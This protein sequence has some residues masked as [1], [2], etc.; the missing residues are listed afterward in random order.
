MAAPDARNE[1]E[2][3]LELVRLEERDGALSPAL[4]SRKRGLEV[5]AARLLESR[6]IPDVNLVQA[7]RSEGVPAVLVP[8]AFGGFGGWLGSGGRGTHMAVQLLACIG[9][10]VAGAIGPAFDRPLQRHLLDLVEGPIS[11]ILLLWGVVYPA[12]LAKAERQATSNRAGLPRIEG[13]LLLNGALLAGAWLLLQQASLT[14]WTASLIMWFALALASIGSV[15]PVAMARL[16]ARVA[17][18]AELA[19]FEALDES[20]SGEARRSFEQAV[21]LAPLSALD[22]EIQHALRVSILCESE[23]LRRTGQ[24][25]RAR[26]LLIARGVDPSSAD[27]VESVERWAVRTGDRKAELFEAAGLHLRAARIYR[28]HHQATQA[29]RCYRL[30]SERPDDPDARRE[31]ALGVVELG[32]AIEGP[33]L[34][35]LLSEIE[36][37]GAQAT[38]AVRVLAILPAEALDSPELVEGL[39]ER[40]GR[41]PPERGVSS[42]EAI[43]GSRSP[44]ELPG[45]FSIL[46]GAYRRLGHRGTARRIES[47]LGPRLKVP[48]PQESRPSVA[49]AADL[50]TGDLAEA[51]SERYS[52]VCRLGAGAM[53][54]VHLAE[55]L[56]LGR[57]VALKVLR[58]QM[59]SDL[60]VE[61][62]K[63]EARVVARLDHPG[64]V[65]VFDAGQVG[66]WTY[67]VMELVDG[68]DLATVT[69]APTHPPIAT[70][71][72]WIVD[73]ASAMA[74]AHAQGVIHRDIKPANILIDSNGRARLTDFGIA[75]ISTPDPDATGFSKAGLQVGTPL[76]M[77]P[78]QL[79]LGS[80][81]G[82][83]TD[84]Y[85]LGVV[86]YYTA[87]G[88]LPFKGDI[89][90]KI[91]NPAPS[92]QEKVPSLS[93]ELD[94]VVR[95]AMAT[96]PE[97]RLPGMSE[98]MERL[99]QC[100]ELYPEVEE[101]SIGSAA[102]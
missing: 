68:P 46:A 96:E 81:P 78:E 5:S 90:S 13:P 26:A 101:R 47:E 91:E 98:L 27:A 44:S 82:P 39:A 71:L 15:R 94:A 89:V 28:E 12:I 10:V 35:G 31:A 8:G 34:D 100:P 65:R 50:N 38:E 77:A 17:R 55:D 74:H 29:L 97:E 59:A 3:L 84:V 20:A 1:V 63:T 32:G 86:L 36:E 99:R 70:L 58:P 66:P 80:P 95:A 22:S 14:T 43:V 87:V 76:Y 52:L 61:K 33:L 7:V 85:A 60:F 41:S 42:V 19:G 56:V 73:I 9:V 23:R 54:E 18:S 64:I 75:H 102:V 40:L 30:V 67:F 45:L 93:V 37:K 57:R 2:E 49:D 48:A 88:E 51:L 6:P 83:S 25:V 24:R 72:G 16:L 92:I 11:Y 21:A 79:S 62:F 53:G 69:S 4:A